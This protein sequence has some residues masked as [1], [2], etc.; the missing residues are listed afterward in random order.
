MYISALVD[1]LSQVGLSTCVVSPGSRSTPLALLMAEHSKL[2]TFVNVDERS[3]AFFALGAA[4]STGI[5]SVLACTSGSAAANFLPAVVEA[6]YA[7]VPM[8]LLTADRPHELREVGA[9]QAI[10]QINMYGQF[11]RAYFEAAIPEDTEQMIAYARNLIRRALAASLKPPAGPVQINIPLR[12]PLIPDLDDP[13]LFSY[14]RATQTVQIDPGRFMLTDTVFDQLAGD[15]SNFRNGIIVC[16]AQSDGAFPEAVIQLAERL[17]YPILADPLSQLRLCGITSEW[18]IDGYDAF[19][20]NENAIA[21]LKPEIILRFGAMPVSKPFLLACQNHWQDI[22]HIVVDGGGEWRDPANVATDM[23]YCDETSFCHE[24]S[25]RITKTTNYNWSSLWRNVNLKTTLALE[26]ISDRHEMNEG[27]VIFELNELLPADSQLFIAN[28]MP[29]RDVDTFILHRSKQVNVLCNRGT[30][31]IDGTTSTALG[32]ALNGK[33]TLLVAGDLS[34]FHDLNGLAATSLNDLS[35]TIVLINN[36][37][38]GIFSFLPQ[39]QSVSAKKHFERLFLTPLALPYEYAAKLYGAEY[40]K[41]ESWEQYRKEVE[42]GLHA[43]G[44]HIIEVQTDRDGN[45][46]LH[47]MLWK[48]VADAIEPVFEEMSG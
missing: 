37:G 2:N 41:V 6:S 22:R 33:P 38:G 12:E 30:N 31:G 5:P 39:A 32:A 29:I 18:I 25:K 7:R 10:N 4:K 44:I 14:G 28:S 23:L 46:A 34:F 17:Q 47:R 35:L 42:K 48:K 19:L 40:S 24:L 8:I 43:K 20:K 21:R 16:G 3:A 9:P 27:R 15:L 26:T 1:E 45:V 36:N 11:T 13:L